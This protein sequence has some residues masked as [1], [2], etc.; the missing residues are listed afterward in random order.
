MIG[1]A[2]TKQVGMSWIIALAIAVSISTSPS[3]AHV[4][5]F[6]MLELREGTGVPAEVVAIYSKG[7]R[8]LADGQ[9][10]DGSWSKGQSRHGNEDCGIC[11]LA[12]MAFLST[13]EDPNFGKYARNI[14][15]AVR[16][17]I[18]HQNKKTGYIPGNMYV[19]GFSMLALSEAYGAVDETMLWEGQS[20][21]RKKQRS[22]GE[23]LELAVRLAVTLSLIHI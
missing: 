3:L 13:G 12:T 18:L 11:A 14:R 17:I 22:I 1:F 8:F 7:V 21:N 23:A 16:Y 19:H 10:D 9:N 15:A 20:K 6:D 4:D 2:L 5:S